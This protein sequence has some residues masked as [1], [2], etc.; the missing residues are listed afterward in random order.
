[1]NT[2]WQFMKRNYKIVLLI[3]ALSAILWSFVPNKKEDPEKDRL[4]LELLTFV[5][6][7]GHYDPIAMD[8]AFS[9]NVYK[10][11]INGIDPSRRFFVQSDIDEFKKYETQIDDMI[12]SKDLKFF[13]LTYTRLIERMN[14]SRKI[15]KEVLDKPFDFN[16]EDNINTDYDKL[17]FSKNKAELKLRWEKQ[18]KLS[19][20]SSITDKLKLEEDKKKKD[21]N[22][23]EKTF[24]EL[25]ADSRE[26]TLKSLND[27]FDFVGE[28]DRNDWFS[29]YLNAIVE[30]FDPHTFYFAPEEKDKFDISM[31]GT[32]EGIGA[33][34]QKKNDITEISELI[35][36]GPAWRG[37]QL[38]QGDLIMKVAQGSDEPVDVVGMRLDDVVKKI[39][40]KKGTEVRL[41]VKKVDGTIKVI[42]IIREVVELEETYAKSSVVKEGGKT[43]GIIYL[44][45]FYIDFENKDKRDAFKDVAQEIERLKAQGVEGIVMDL[46]DNGG[47]SLQTV[48]DM[49]GLFIEEGPVVQVKSSGKKKDVLYDKDSRVQWDGPLVVMV[50][51]FSAS[52]SE[53]FA[54]AIQDYKRG[55]VIGSKHTYGKGT[56]QNLIDLNQ[57][58]RSSSFGDLGALK[59]TTQKFYR[60]NGGSTQREGVLS[61]I[62]MPDRYSYIEMG[63][64]D[65][66]NAMPWDKI[67]EASYKV[68][69][70]AT[71]EDVIAKSKARMASS[72]QFRLIDENAKWINERKDINTYSLNYKKFRE[73]ENSV[74]AKAKKFKAIVDYKSNLKFTS[75]P[76]EQ[77]IFKKDS[78][79][80]QKRE[81]WHESLS[82][83]VYV[84]EAL[85]ILS[86]MKSTSVL[87]GTINL[88]DKKN[89]L[90]EVK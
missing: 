82:S 31:S 32:L 16:K 80:A 72:E 59:T 85:N 20:L 45:K 25:E 5:L 58:V 62:V 37:K 76:Y 8:D 79:L 23:K 65:V 57:F 69:K 88:K 10:E 13:E 22:Y 34:L 60:I 90:A 53:I 73:E 56:V 26:T 19:V 68:T 42:S 75:L 78:L 49:V 6:E 9:K 54:A 81:R 64:R 43:F 2:F 40:G 17:P 36:G 89:K 84:E 15:Y 27:Y 47:G 14:E 38:E 55:I 35:P 71:F 48:V 11:Y 46:R 3:T 66:E 30:R 28:L 83:D 51:N 24:A 74:E 77:E 70:N 7:K 18:L 12:K 1:M 39:K 63:E 44:P 33:R 21:A 67:D 86:D 52:A 29:I 87:K 50:N 41:T 4:L 61:D